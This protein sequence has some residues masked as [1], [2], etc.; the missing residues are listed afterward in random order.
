MTAKA[1]TEVIVA[2]PTI[3]ATVSAAHTVTSE[4]QYATIADLQASTSLIDGVAYIVSDPIQG[5]LFTKDTSGESPDHHNY[6]TL[7][8]EDGNREQV[9]TTGTDSGGGTVSVAMPAGYIRGSLV[10]SDDVETFTEDVQGILSGTNGG[11]GYVNVKSNAVAYFGALGTTGTINV[12]YTKAVAPAVLRRLGQDGIFRPEWFD[13]VGNFRRNDISHDAT[14]LIQSAWNE[15]SLYQIDSGRSYDRSVQGHCV[16]SSGYYYM[17]ELGVRGAAFRGQGQGQTFL[18]PLKAPA[19]GVVFSDY[20]TLGNPSPTVDRL[21]FQDFSISCEGNT[22]WQGWQTEVER[23]DVSAFE[24]LKING[25]DF[26]NLGIY[27]IKRNGFNFL[28][29]QDC[30]LNNIEILNCGT[31]TGT[32]GVDAVGVMDYWGL[33]FDAVDA[34]TNAM[35]MSSI[36]I[37]KCPG[38]MLL[39][40]SSVDTDPRRTVTASQFHDIKLHGAKSDGSVFLQA[41]SPVQIL[42]GDNICFT[43]LYMVNTQAML[44]PDTPFMVF[45]GKSVRNGLVNIVGGT[46]ANGA[47]YAIQN[48]PDVSNHI[49]NITGVTAKGAGTRWLKGRFNV[50]GCS[51]D[52]MARPHMELEKSV[53]AGYQ[54]GPLEAGGEDNYAIIANDSSLSDVRVVTGTKD[55]DSV[56]FDGCDVKGLRMFKEGGSGSLVVLQDNCSLRDFTVTEGTVPE[57]GFPVKVE[58]VNNLIDGAFGDVTGFGASIRVSD[59]AEVHVF[60]SKVTGA[61]T[62]FSRGTGALLWNR[63]PKFTNQSGVVGEDVTGTFYENTSTL[64]LRVMYEMLM[65]TGDVATLWY[66]IDGVNTPIKLDMYRAQ[67]DNIKVMLVGEIDPGDFWRLDYSGT[68]SIVNSY[69]Q[70]V[71]G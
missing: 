42:S 35:H 67:S 59:N 23:P 4:N 29:A 47:G 32:I 61:N 24:F 6:A 8:V 63:T 51:S 12:S 44:T 70:P 64:K 14:N 28:R 54:I 21:R 52:N 33:R 48:D 69:G 1:N 26:L 22:P 62:G 10:I 60:N 30:Y 16:L 2:Q 43:N 5:G 50:S 65:S 58:G 34:N 3:E 17:G 41:E 31:V 55:Q 71:G 11:D 15:A 18:V 66:S 45:S 7:V 9:V 19:G 49:V 36:R 68:S 40:N 46:I 57:G 37:E 13:T 27:N 53:V 38:L 56:Y 39:E 25:G 20:G